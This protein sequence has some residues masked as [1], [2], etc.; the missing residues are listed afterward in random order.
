MATT[1]LST[2]NLPNKLRT[3]QLKSE[4]TNVPLP[5]AVTQLPSPFNTLGRRKREYE[6]YQQQQLEAQ[7]AAKNASYKQVGG[8]KDPNDPYSLNS[9][10][11]IMNTEAIAKRYGEWTK[12]WW[13]RSFLGGA[14]WL[15]AAADVAIVQPMANLFTGDFKAL[16]INTLT[17]F[18]ETM[19]I[20]ANPIKSLIA[21]LVASEEAKK[22][23]PEKYNQPWY[24]RLISGTRGLGAMLGQAA[25]MTG[26]LDTEFGHLS[27]VGEYN[28]D[29][30]TGFWLSDM[31]LEIVSDPMNLIGFG[32]GVAKTG[33]K[34]AGQ[35]INIFGKI[36]GGKGAE[37][38]GKQALDTVAKETADTFSKQATKKLGHQI[39]T[40]AL[41]LTK[42][43]TEIS[44]LAKNAVSKLGD[45]GKGILDIASNLDEVLANT[46]GFISD[47]AIDLINGS[48]NKETG[49]LVGGIL[50][51]TNQLL[52][53]KTL[54]NSTRT[55]LEKLDD[56]TKNFTK[57]ST[58][59]AGD[60]LRIM[61]ADP[62]DLTKIKFTAAGKIQLDDIDKLFKKPIKE[63]GTSA[64]QALADKSDAIKGF[65][66]EATAKFNGEQLETLLDSPA[67]IKKYKG[68]NFSDDILNVADQISLVD[69]LSS[70]NA[71]IQESDAYKVFKAADELAQGTE[72]VD[73]AVLKA[74][75]LGNPFTAGFYF[76][77]KAEPVKTAIGD[78]V[79]K[80]VIQKLTKVADFYETKLTVVDRAMDF[81]EYEDAMKR[82][83]RKINIFSDGA[84]EAGDWSNDL[85]RTVYDETWAWLRGYGDE[86]AYFGQRP[87]NL[88]LSQND[89][90]TELRRLYPDKF[91]PEMPAEEIDRIFFEQFDALYIKA[92]TGNELVRWDWQGYLN[93][94][95]ANPNMEENVQ[96]LWSSLSKPLEALDPAY[97][98]S[99]GSFVRA[100]SG[101]DTSSARKSAQ[102]IVGS[103]QKLVPNITDATGKL[104]NQ[105]DLRTVF[106][107]AIKPVRGTLKQVDDAA[108]A[109][110]S[111]FK[112]LQQVE[113][114]EQ[115]ITAFKAIAG[116][117]PIEIAKLQN[118]INDLYVRANAQMTLYIRN[119]A[120]VI[121][122]KAL[123]SKAPL[124]KLY[125]KL[126]KSEIISPYFGKADV[127]R[128]ESKKFV[129]LKN[130]QQMMTRTILE[131]EDFKYIIQSLRPGQDLNK[132]VNS[133]MIRLDTAIKD[134]VALGPR[135]NLGNVIETAE[136]ASLRKQY[137]KMQSLRTSVDSVDAYIEHIGILEQS[138]LPEGLRAVYLDTLHSFEQRDATK[139]M[140]NFNSNYYVFKK[141]MDQQLYAK[142]YTHQMTLEYYGRKMLLKPEY[143]ERALKYLSNAHTAQADAE[144]CQLL[145]E[146]EILPE[147]SK[148]EDIQITRAGKTEIIQKYAH[149]EYLKL[150]DRQF[151]YFDFETTGLN[152]NI[153]QIYEV[154]LSTS[155]RKSWSASHHNFED[156][157]CTEA[158]KRQ[159]AARGG[160]PL[161]EGSTE[162]EVLLS[163]YKQLRE[164]QEQTGKELCFV[165]HNSQNFD[166]QFLQKRFTLAAE[167]ANTADNSE[168]MQQLIE[169]KDWIGRNMEAA[170][171]DTL[172]Q[173]KRMEGIPCVGEYSDQI[174]NLL[175]SYVARQ[176]NNNADLVFNLPSDFLDS[177]KNLPGLNINNY[178]QH[179]DSL[180][181]L[182]KEMRNSNQIWSSRIGNL[183]DAGIRTVL[184]GD[185]YKPYKDLV[186]HDGADLSDTDI[187]KLISSQEVQVTNPKELIELK[188]GR[189]YYQGTALPTSIKTSNDA[190][191]YLKSNVTAYAPSWKAL[192]LTQQ[193]STYPVLIDG[194]LVLETL[195][196][197]APVAF[198]N[199]I[200]TDMISQ[201]FKYT[202][203]DLE[204]NHQLTVLSQSM[205]S[206]LSR[207]QNAA[208][209]KIYSEIYSKLYSEILSELSKTDGIWRYLK[210]DTNV[211]Q[212]FAI[213]Y[214]ILNDSE[215][216]YSG[217]IRSKLKLPEF[218]DIQKGLLNPQRTIFEESDYV[219]IF[220][221]YERNTRGVYTEN[222]L[223]RNEY[224]ER[225][226]DTQ[227]RTGSHSAQDLR[228]A[229]E[230]DVDY[231]TQYTQALSSGMDKHNIYSSTMQKHAI[232]GQA[233]I[234]LDKTYIDFINGLKDGPEFDTFMSLDKQLTNNLEDLVLA[235]VLQMNTESLRS[236]V[237]HQ[238]KGVVIIPAGAYLAD[239]SFHSFDIKPEL[240]RFLQQYNGYED[241]FIK[242][243]KKGDDLI[244]YA[245]DYTTNMKLN[246]IPVRQLKQLDYLKAFDAA[247]GVDENILEQFSQITSGSLIEMDTLR[248]IEKGS[249]E[250][251]AIYNDIIK[252]P[253]RAQ[254]FLLTH[255][256]E[257]Q[258]LRAAHERQ[259]NVMSRLSVDFDEQYSMMSGG[260]GRILDT[261]GMSEVFKALPDEVRI[262]VLNGQ[263]IESVYNTFGSIF[264]FTTLGR[265]QYRKAY[266]PFATSSLQ[267]VQGQA[268][269]QM[270]YNLSSVSQYAQ[271]FYEDSPL[272]LKNFYANANDSQIFSAV[273]MSEDYTVSYMGFDKKGLP[274]AIE[275][276]INTVEDVTRAKELGA[277]LL[278]NQTFASMAQAIN[279]ARWANSKFKVFHKIN[280]ALKVSMLILTPGFIF[281]NLLDSTIKNFAV[282]RDVT[283]MMGSY[284][285]AMDYYRRYTETIQMLFGLDPDHPFRPDTLRMLFDNN[286]PPMDEE[287]FMLI[288]NF[289]ENGP[290][291]GSVG[292]VADFYLKDQAP[293]L[294]QK[295]YETA[296]IPTK[297]LEQIERLSEYV[298]LIKTGMT[299]TAAYNV[300]TKTHFD[301][302][303]KSDLAR[304][305]ELVIP[306]YSFQIKNFEFWLDMIDKNPIL[307]ANLS[308]YLTPAWNFDDID[309]ERIKYYESRLN[310]IMQANLILN[311]KGLTL[312][313][314]PSFIDPLSLL[315]NPIESLSGR[316]TPLFKPVLDLMQQNDPKGYELQFAQLLGAATAPIP[317]V[318]MAGATLSAGA[319]IT[320]RY[321][322]GIRA[323]QRTSSNLPLIAPSIFGST[324]TPAQYG[325]A[326][327]SNSRTF[328]D[329]EMRRPRRV[330][331][332]N[333]LYTDTGKN[334]WKLRMLPMDAATVQYRIRDNQ[335]RF[336]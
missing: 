245:K 334:R 83:M 217:L 175:Q 170:N 178:Q 161:T 254:E 115:Q 300:V 196:G 21:P 237:Y 321:Q 106:R 167:A 163:F 281:R 19:D 37:T 128:S 325:K 137:N 152:P 72:A 241:E 261:D 216:P 285:D 23:D 75:L 85:A 253:K 15:T 49:K 303:A 160:I 131:S 227:Q 43:A 212:Q 250:W 36:I 38:V 61:H 280:Y 242:V 77:L 99:A 30:D 34:L 90:A 126:R 274:K 67:L 139:F 9:I 32:A 51:Q 319:Q 263:P 323:N 198:R 107:S 62:S 39:I 184:D 309:F 201:F 223:S 92:S 273:N 269:R 59:S 317:G 315:A 169:A 271:F 192:N 332:Y 60:L 307:I 310:Q 287:L 208:N 97:K 219:R 190:V 138:G 149:K 81:V 54:K 203:L 165:G 68:I 205:S 246:K 14:L 284:I 299:N 66:S 93:G 135:D 249:L 304:M 86:A 2:T 171:L 218:K 22:K 44:Q 231:V 20:F 63:G 103:I 84:I 260:Y 288:H 3:P 180:Y 277:V 297:G 256:Y 264:N 157:D 202:E 6:A 259:F 188:D 168:L 228:N 134:A 302:A 162:T 80:H 206:V 100:I 235:Q 230:R 46:K 234:D 183:N 8:I 207:I 247:Y 155:G 292:Q 148:F 318:N 16:G 96:K 130:S 10:V 329:A 313:L 229:L 153:D 70:A 98:M 136:I 276:P 87:R 24:K 197:I 283:G 179:I 11:D 124:V 56:L 324:K 78:F 251:Q 314:N 17:N 333:K 238:G 13:A 52:A 111:T 232:L 213:L 279:S 320:Q 121:N 257:I 328:S 294:V 258:K 265:A 55:A 5:T 113:Q 33:S 120:P 270:S 1:N 7:Q 147:L 119:L 166:I 239:K 102:S 117:D 248:F 94:I 255:Y 132:I 122:A 69:Y 143:R 233:Q 214:S 240:M 142:F 114:L 311:Q 177:I 42:N 199:S 236:F 174:R 76:T 186:F 200:D 215:N 164:I 40:E 278:P 286:V 101:V 301:Y 243:L 275:V 306:F 293:S 282:T 335:N 291:A 29:Y 123:D 226:Y 26:T 172:S 146:S 12:S 331:I 31:A 158:A 151:V 176:M 211:Y 91:K 74:A 295:F 144:F 296:M 35:G 221:T 290:S 181:E 330:N 267:S 108:V 194:Q 118:T 156:I 252:S 327:Y 125:N 45:A 185:Y 191:R 262:A 159:L 289:I 41:E 220:E 193:L 116:Y 244:I 222:Y 79:K 112:A 140:K 95:K 316:V 133:E 88:M 305:I 210:V 28:W 127:L 105:A 58:R 27:D 209:I 89:R 268:Y 109:L 224:I 65:L 272:A 195:E 64:I 129:E 322:T 18:S 298:Q 326:S 154:G 82:A 104:I 48:V 141:K 173:L 182:F 308:N 336:R 110:H 187:Q 53:D 71:F 25:A 225:I 145:F 47:K 4:T 50:E 189:W 57:A 312:K 73:K 204:I 266:E 150:K